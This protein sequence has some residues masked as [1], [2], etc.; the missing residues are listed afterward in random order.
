[1]GQSDVS[2]SSCD[3]SHSSG[4]GGVPG[5]K[6]CMIQGCEK[7]GSFILPKVPGE[8]GVGRVCRLHKVSGCIPAPGAGRECAGEGCNKRSNYGDAYSYGPRYCA[9]HKA[10]H[11]VNLNSPRCE[12]MGCGR[13]PSFGDVAEGTPRFCRE[14]R[15]A[16][17]ANVRHARCEGPE[18][19]KIPAFGFA[20]GAARFCVS[21]KPAAAVNV[22]RMRSR[23]STPSSRAGRS[24]SVEQDEVMRLR[25]HACAV[26]TLRSV[27][28][29][30]GREAAASCDGGGVESRIQRSM[31]AVSM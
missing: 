13:Q 4:G 6:T 17:D 2:V 12:R 26:E 16:G 24:A 14:H 20:G 7:R 8:G 15:R 3:A 23:S 9:L 22:L 30:G 28:A 5:L 31:H 25:H 19:A 27:A 1:M 29:A 10:P 11:H 21:H 18:C